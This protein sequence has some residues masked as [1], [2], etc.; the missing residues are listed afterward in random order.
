ML[1]LRVWKN[2]VIVFKAFCSFIEYVE[3]TYHAQTYGNFKAFH[4][5]F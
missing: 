2:P 3:N 5:G 4:A 1:L